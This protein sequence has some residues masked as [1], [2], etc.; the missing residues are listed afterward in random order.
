MKN[1]K[2][3]ASI[4]TVCLLLFLSTENNVVLSESDDH[5][6]YIEVLSSNNH[7]AAFEKGFG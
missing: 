7:T 2:Y 5:V 3:I 4:I 6:E 1:L